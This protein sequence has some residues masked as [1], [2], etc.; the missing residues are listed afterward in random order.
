MCKGEEEKHMNNTL[1]KKERK[2]EENRENERERNIRKRAAYIKEE[3]INNIL[4][5]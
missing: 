2:K 4:R 5:K 1:R 3:E